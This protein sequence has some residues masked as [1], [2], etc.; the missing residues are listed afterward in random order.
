MRARSLRL[1][2]R[3]PC[4]SATPTA[5]FAV[6]S[7]SRYKAAQTLTGKHSSPAH[8]KRQSK[9]WADENACPPVNIYIVGSRLEWHPV[10]MLVGAAPRCENAKPIL[11]EISDSPPPRDSGHAQARP[12]GTLHRDPPRAAVRS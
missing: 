8:R 2:R 11:P 7:S 12:A 9:V 4:R 5:V 1:L 3:T 6:Q 10:V